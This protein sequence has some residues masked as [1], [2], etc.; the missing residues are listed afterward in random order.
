[1]SKCK[2]YKP[3]MNILA[4]LIERFYQLKDCGAGGPLHVLLDD[5]NYDIDTVHFCLNYC[6]DGLIKQ[7][8][9]ES[10]DYDKEVYILGILICNEYAKMSLEE[11]ATFDSYMCGYNSV[12]SC[13]GNCETCNIFD[14]EL[15]EHMEEK[16]KEN[17]L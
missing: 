11:R 7:Q 3:H 4:S 13:P 16:E 14:N 12:V 2:Y 6:F 17:E 9:G 8:N 5:D 10:A 1:M 15:Y